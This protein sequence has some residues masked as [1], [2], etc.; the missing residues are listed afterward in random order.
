MDALIAFWSYALAAA[1]FLALVIWRLK[2]AAR[3]PAQRLLAASFA[4]TGCW[5]WLSAVTPGDPLVGF[6]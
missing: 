1:T 5:A 3:Q 4:V 2:D 6:A